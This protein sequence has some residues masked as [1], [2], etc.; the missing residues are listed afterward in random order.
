MLGLVVV[1][2]GD[3]VGQLVAGEQDLLAQRLLLG[4]DHGRRHAPHLGGELEGVHHRLHG[5]G[6]QVGGVVAAHPVDRV[7][8]DAA[9]A[10]EQP[11]PARRVHARHAQVRHVRTA[12]PI[13]AHH[14]VPALRRLGG[15]GGLRRRLCLT[16]ANLVAMAVRGARRGQ[17]G[18]DQRR[19][20]GVPEACC[21]ACCGH[22]RSPL[23]SIGSPAPARRSSRPGA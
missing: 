15:G 12:H 13:R 8:G 14:L 17:P 22:D 4:V 9:L 11:A 19:R 23:S 20:Q 16:L 10:D 18:R 1:H 6:V 2:E 21:V 5:V 3:D 7:T